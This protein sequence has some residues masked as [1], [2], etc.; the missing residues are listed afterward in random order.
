MFHAHTDYKGKEATSAEEWMTAGSWLRKKDIEGC[1]DS[2]ILPP[3]QKKSN[4]I[5]RNPLGDHF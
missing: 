1:C 2:P 4:K 5:D 3:I